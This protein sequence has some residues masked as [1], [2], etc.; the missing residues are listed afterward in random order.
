M[1]L[2]TG[3]LVAQD[4]YVTDSVSSILRPTCGRPWYDKSRNCLCIEKRPG[5]LPVSLARI[6]SVSDR[7]FAN[8]L[9][10]L[11]VQDSYPP[12]SLEQMT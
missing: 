7:S 8:C 10:Q 11:R 9:Q 3:L 4:F 6:Q 5:I 1:D 12:V 2:R